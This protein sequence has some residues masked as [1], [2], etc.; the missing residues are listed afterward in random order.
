MSSPGHRSDFWAEIPPRPAPYARMLRQGGKRCRSGCEKVMLVGEWVPRFCLLSQTMQFLEYNK[1][2][3]LEFARRGRFVILF[4]K[5]FLT[6]NHCFSSH[7]FKEMGVQLTP[8]EF[9]GFQG[10]NTPK[11][12]F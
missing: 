8:D 12:C 4:R 6:S 1:L 11:D 5:S 3:N 9:S 10:Q 2:M 7:S